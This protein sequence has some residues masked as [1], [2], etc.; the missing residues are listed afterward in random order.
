M[1][2]KMEQIVSISLS[3]DGGISDRH[4]I[5][6]YDVSQAL[7]G[8]QRS[9]A[10]TTHLILNGE[11]ITQSPSLKGAQILASPAEEGSWKIVAAVFAGI[12]AIGT[13]PKDT[14]LG[15]MVH[16]VYDYVVS[17]SL[18]E[19]VDYDKSLGELFEVHNRSKKKSISLEQHKVDSLIEKCSTAI[20]EIHRPIFKT[21]TATNARITSNLNGIEVPVGPKFSIQTYQYI[22]EEFIAEMP[23]II[24]GRISSY[25]SNTYKGR[26]YVVAEGRPVAFELSEDCRSDYSVTLVTSSLSSNA[27]K[28]YD[29]EWC[30]IYCRVFKNTSRSGHLKSYRILEISHDTLE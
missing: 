1:N 22:H 30:T 29:S 23:E 4:Q 13:A 11:I 5:D 3:F 26:I 27:L 16:S 8:F 7:I 2:D 28:E 25:N 15:H 17:E 18:G 20:T 14:P 6:L 10:L 9:I 12:Y 19:H 24:K 21:N